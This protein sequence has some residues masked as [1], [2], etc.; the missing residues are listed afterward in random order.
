[1]KWEN[2]EAYKPTYIYSVKYNKTRDNKLLAVAG[3]NK[4]L[5][6]ILI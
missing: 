2:N 6:P 1:M 3:V 5:L 4:P